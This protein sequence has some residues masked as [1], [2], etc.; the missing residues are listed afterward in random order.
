MVES[1]EPL[2][3]SE[4]HRSDNDLERRLVADPQIVMAE[5]RPHDV[6][7]KVQSVGDATLSDDTATKTINSQPFGDVEGGSKTT[8]PNI[9]HALPPTNHDTSTFP[10]EPPYL[11]GAIGTV[12]VN[13]TLPSSSGEVPSSDLDARSGLLSGQTES[14]VLE[15]D[16][17]QP[18]AGEGSDNEALKQE[19]SDTNLMGGSDD[20]GHIRSN[21]VKKPTSFKAVSVTRNFLAKAATG[22]TPTSKPSGEK[23][24][25]PS[26]IGSGTPVQPMMR[27]RLIAKS[28]TG[29]RDAAPRKSSVSS[30][31]GR[32][33]GPDPGQVWNK[34]RP[35]Q[36]QAPKQFTDEELKQQYGIHLA[37]RLQADEAGK[38]AKWADIDD[39]DDDWAPET[40]EW[41]DGTKITLPH[42]EEQSV[43]AQFDLALAETPEAALRLDKPIEVQKA[44]SPA[45]QDNPSAESVKPMHA[46][47]VNGQVKGNGLVL[48][49]A[50]EKPTLV[51]KPLVPTPVK[52]PWAPLPPVERAPVSVHTQQQH[53]QGQQ[54]Q[55]NSRFGQKDPHGFDSMPPPLS[56]TQEIA[57]DDFSRSWRDTHAGSNRELFNSHSGRY[58]PV[59]EN[60]RGSSKGDQ[61]FR[62]PSV[63]QRPLPNDHRGVAE[64]SAAFQTNRSSA[65][66]GPWGRRRTSSNVSG[67]SGNFARRMSMSKGQDTPAPGDGRLGPRQ[68]SQHGVQSD[69]S[70]SPRDISPSRVHPQS[71]AFN[72]ARSYN[73]APPPGSQ[74]SWQARTSPTLNHNQVLPPLGTAATPHAAQDPPDETTEQT[75]QGPQA[76]DPVEV[77]KK[78]M[79]EG[80]EQAMKRRREQEEKEE[81][82]RR[83]RIRLKME[84]MGLP[85]LDENRGKA[86]EKSAEKPADPLDS[87]TM[88][89]AKTGLDTKTESLSPTSTADE[90]RQYGVMRVHQPETVKTQN[91]TSHRASSQ[92]AHRRL[93]SPSNAA[94]PETR[95]SVKEPRAEDA[96]G[97]P[98]EE[99]QI[100]VGAYDS[101][102][103]G[104]PS[105][106]QKPW[107]NVPAGA[108]TY[109]SWGTNNMTTHSTAGGNLWGPPSN[110]KALGNGTFDRLPSRPL[111]NLHKGVPAPGPGSIGPPSPSHP[112][113]L[114]QSLSPPSATG[115]EKLGPRALASPTMGHATA[116]LLPSGPVSDTIR[117]PGR[118]TPPTLPVK[119]PEQ[120]R[121]SALA[122]WRGLSAELERSETEERE[123]A[124]AQR[125][126]RLKEEALSGVQTEVPQPAFKETWRQI[127]VNRDG[128]GSRRVVGVAKPTPGQDVDDIKKLN[129]GSEQA[130]IGPPVIGTTS[131]YPHPVGNGRGSRFFPH[132][133]DKSQQQNRDTSRK[134]PGSD[135][136]SSSP[137][138]DSADHP[139]YYGDVSRPHVSLPAPKP[140][141]KLPPALAEAGPPQVIEPVSRNEPSP[142]KSRSEQATGSWQDRINGLFN[143]QGRPNNMAV[144]SG[145][146]GALDNGTQYFVPAT[147]SLP[148]KSNTSPISGHPKRNW[149]SGANGEVTTKT[150][151][152]ALFEEREFGS[153]PPVRIPKYESKTPWQPVRVSPNA[154][155]R[156]RYQK[157]A[158]V[159]SKESLVFR[160]KE[161]PQGL[162]IEVRLPG[163]RLVKSFVQSRTAASPNNRT[164]TATSP[165]WKDKRRPTRPRDSSG[166]FTPTK[167]ASNSQRQTGVPSGSWARR[168]S[169]TV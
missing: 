140:V 120:Q 39:D 155:A 87:S 116:H 67:G 37:T 135:E 81:A 93:S 36:P 28:G 141:V 144:A 38:E 65:Q 77:Q 121:S 154:R 16:L 31:A 150:T 22:S 63:L 158:V 98:K 86:P 20:K 100:N 163:N 47:Q 58:E 164:P 169:G 57:A 52:S 106:Q 5:Q 41:N 152:E 33:S 168:V 115:A 151:E 34:N 153:L 69:I 157:P 102:K 142:L 79:R 82:D 59:A 105:P 9:P 32:G 68:G 10:P 149:L 92:G 99:N 70:T 18:S 111:S 147:V 3:V 114:T 25:P 101:T 55:S 96:L 89:P 138:P 126:A 75:N 84:S 76:E 23:A 49:G 40:I 66:D 14:A 30:G 72:Q 12:E 78:I 112:P 148:R 161:T 15:E 165:H 11:N 83:E 133:S 108:D 90:V 110:D 131:S 128:T 125:A 1:D 145:T 45:S 6:V 21:S 26:A 137:P 156:P 134:T 167:S 130:P 104:P 35:A 119:A 85:P 73:Q 107:K 97:V 61:H 129:I 56:P 122:A 109:T 48:K 46:S 88:P 17:S 136:F 43:P 13:S 124:A 24:M 132:I 8:T 162:V 2:A 127:S 159:L 19:V 80:R 44:N 42:H 51:A 94:K 103:H 29:L 123:R 7:D 54:L 62:H 74:Q 113:S 118:P 91:V 71:Q 60:R 139:A 143:R 146:R 95:T 53:N 50:P 166:S 64:P 117:Q 160:D 27:P 4:D